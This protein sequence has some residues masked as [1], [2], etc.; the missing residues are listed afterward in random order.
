MKGGD[1]HFLGVWGLTSVLMLCIVFQH[2]ITITIMNRPV[3]KND[4]QN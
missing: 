2:R 1:F 3:N 4:E